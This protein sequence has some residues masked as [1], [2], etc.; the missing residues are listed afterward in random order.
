MSENLNLEQTAPLIS[1]SVTYGN[2]CK[3]EQEVIPAISC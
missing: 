2:A 1:N 3:S